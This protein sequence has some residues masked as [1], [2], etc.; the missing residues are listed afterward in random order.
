MVAGTEIVFPVGSFHRFPYGPFFCS[1]ARIFV[2]DVE[3][4]CN[5]IVFEI[6]GCGKKVPA[7]FRA[8]DFYVNRPGDVYPLQIS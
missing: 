7:P 2:S 1:L 8:R 3:K 6:Q 4:I 5:G